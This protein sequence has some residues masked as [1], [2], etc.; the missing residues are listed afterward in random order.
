[1]QRWANKYLRQINGIL[2][3]ASAYGIIAATDPTGCCAVQTPAFFFSQALCPSVWRDSQR[4]CRRSMR[5]C[6]AVPVLE[7]MLEA[8]RAERRCEEG[9]GRIQVDVVSGPQAVWRDEGRRS[10]AGKA[11]ILADQPCGSSET[12]F[13][14][15]LVR[16]YVSGRE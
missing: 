5:W 13:G 10:A 1:M 16:G 15:S 4:W 9:E 12:A 11:S 14:G 2:Q 7:R 6:C 3:P 8:G